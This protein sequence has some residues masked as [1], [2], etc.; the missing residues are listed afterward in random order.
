MTEHPGFGA[1]LARLLDHRGLGDPDAELL[2]RLAP[3]L[4]LHTVDLF[5]LARQAVPDD[6]APLDATAAPWVKSTAERR[7][8]LRLVRSLPQEKRRSR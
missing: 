8:L 4:G 5:L 7:D 2:R 3:A 6:L 1:L